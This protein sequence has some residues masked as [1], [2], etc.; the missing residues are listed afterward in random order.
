MAAFPCTHVLHADPDPVLLLQLRK[1]IE[2]A[3]QGCR[4]AL[5]HLV[6]R[7]ISRVN[8]EMGCTDTVADIKYVADNS[9]RSAPYPFA[10]RCTIDLTVGAWTV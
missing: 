7:C 2:R 8:N 5:L 3:E 1:L 6:V 10:D 4:R 9:N